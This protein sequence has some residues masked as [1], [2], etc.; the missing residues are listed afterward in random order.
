MDEYSPRNY[1]IAVLKYL[2]FAVK[3]HKPSSEA[4]IIGLMI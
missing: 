4:I 1:D 2:N 3:A